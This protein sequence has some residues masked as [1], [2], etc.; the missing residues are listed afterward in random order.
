MSKLALKKCNKL[1]ET[2]SK[3][4][5]AGEG[6]FVSMPER[7]IKDSYNIVFNSGIQDSDIYSDG[8]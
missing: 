7:Q 1:P 3:F 4:L 5:R 8:A 2:Q 6:H